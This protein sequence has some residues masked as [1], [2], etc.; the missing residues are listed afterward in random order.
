MRGPHQQWRK[1]VVTQPTTFVGVAHQKVLER[2]IKLY[3][4][5]AA[6]D[7][8][9]PRLLV[10]EG[11][12][13]AGKSRIVQEFYGYL[14]AEQTSRYWV[15]LEL[16]GHPKDTRKVMG[17][18]PSTFMRAAHTLPEFSWWSLDCRGVGAQLEVAAQLGDQAKVHVEALE[19]AWATHAT[20]LQRLGNSASTA[21]GLAAD[22]AESV[23][24][25]LAVG[26][27]GIAVPGIGVLKDWAFKFGSLVKERR[28]ADQRFRSDVHL[29]AELAQHR[30]TALQ[31]LAGAIRSL[32]LPGM[33][34]V[35]VIED[36]HLMTQPLGE[37]LDELLPAVAGHP[38]L[39]VA[40]S[41]PE[42]RGSR[43]G[44]ANWL[45][46]AASRGQAAVENVPMLDAAA[47]ESLFRS[48]TAAQSDEVIAELVRRYRNPFMIRL[49]LGHRRFLSG[50]TMADVAELP[51]SVTAFYK[52][53]WAELPDGTK[54]ALRLAARALATRG[55]D[56]ALAPFIA[57]VIESAAA[58]VGLPVP[59]EVAKAED[60]FQWLRPQAGGI[61][62]AE[63]ELF[64]I[65]ADEWGELGSDG[66]AAE[67]VA[68]VHGELE[69][70][71]V[72]RCGDDGLLRWG[73]EED[74]AAQWFLDLP[75]SA[76]GQL[77]ASLAAWHLAE[78]AAQCGWAGDA[79]R[80]VSTWQVG[81]GLSSSISPATSASM[82]R[83]L[84][85]WFFDHG[86]ERH[87]LERLDAAIA[88]ASAELGDTHPETLALRLNQSVVAAETTTKGGQF[89]SVDRD[90]GLEIVEPL[91][92]L[93]DDA[94]R[95]LGPNDEFTIRVRAHLLRWTEIVRGRSGEG[96][97]TIPQWDELLA[98]TDNVLGET[99]DTS[100]TVL[101]LYAEARGLSDKGRV[102]LRE[103]LMDRTAAGKGPNSPAVLSARMD[104]ARDLQWIRGHEQEA[105]TLLGEVAAELLEQ[106][107]PQHPETVAA[108]HSQLNVLDNTASREKNLR[109]TRLCY[110]AATRLLADA[111]RWLGDQHH[112][113]R[114]IEYFVADLGEPLRAM[115]AEVGGEFLADLMYALA[116]HDTDPVALEALLESLAKSDVPFFDILLVLSDV[117]TTCLHVYVVLVEGEIAATGAA[118][119]WLLDAANRSPD[120]SVDPREFKSAFLDGEM[121]R[122]SQILSNPDEHPNELVEE[123]AQLQ[124]GLTVARELE[125]GSRTT[126]DAVCAG[127]DEWRA[128]LGLWGLFNFVFPE[129][130]GMG[131]E[132]KPVVEMVEELSVAVLE[133]RNG[134]YDA[135]LAAA[136]CE[137]RGPV[138]DSADR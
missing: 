134:T 55:N 58:S 72:S 88:I 82:M 13:G 99:H 49:L 132:G 21:K 81:P 87:A 47:A 42:G 38:V 123:A 17:P 85:M 25:D 6:G 22:A 100:M 59:G 94:T 73:P 34:A 12:S 98:T 111:R 129:I 66:Q 92:R 112:E 103:M 125:A 2:I 117:V 109:V 97:D 4:R 86:Q 114:Q 106:L 108:R 26:A 19:R 62:F 104:Y 52:E 61:A 39:V 57:S 41:W 122:S 127:G 76:P 53:R 115:E 96:M 40:T 36:L 51:G 9:V 56:S 93:L 28:E 43:E 71:L 77:A 8:S 45:A 119:P 30:R 1:R 31:D 89:L 105:F 101:R 27:V 20:A 7:E 133:V 11:G 63:P 90:L 137:Y 15:P 24:V 32:S 121:A 5:I 128:F 54:D 69:R 135:W 136:E 138:S 50:M 46:D 79:L 65:A 29:G 80:Y 33:P 120:G 130:V 70:F 16:D 84:S 3:E 23:L 74:L 95:E 14:V 126:L 131:P 35:V 37:F 110:V 67:F 10:L 102:A 18:D 68:E 75:D 124:L 83:S 78:Q 44:Y 48:S 118:P 60:P 116:I 113:T 64:D 107:G 91:E